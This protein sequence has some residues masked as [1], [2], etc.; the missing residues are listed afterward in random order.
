ML[1]RL[2]SYED[3]AY[4]LD[5]KSPEELDAA[6]RRGALEP[7]RKG[8]NSNRFRM[9]DV[10][11]YKLAQAIENVGV[12]AEKATSYAQAILGPRLPAEGKTVLEWIENETQELYCLMADGEL[13]R[14]FLR[15]KED[16]KEFD[17]GAVKPVLFPTVLTEINVFR[18]IRPVIY[19]ARHLLGSCT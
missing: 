2:V 1:S 19:R 12:N 10:I 16:R 6:V 8:P 7:V 5:V 15:N 13:A 3:A 9:P 17:I 14:I 18:V 4:I 11:M